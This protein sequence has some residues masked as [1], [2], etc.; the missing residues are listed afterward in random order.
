MPPRKP[1]FLALL[2]LAPAMAALAQTAPA[3]PQNATPG[4][5]TDQQPASD[6]GLFSPSRT[7][8]FGSLF[9]L[10]PLAADAGITFGLTETSEVLAN[11]T[12]G[13]HTGPA[14]E[15]LT[16][17]SLGI[18][19]QKAFGWTGGTFNAS[20]LQI[21]G[22]NLS[23]D[24]TLNLNTP[25]GIE[26]DRATRLWEL[27]YQQTF[28]GGHADLKI[29]QQ[30]IDQEFLTSA[31][32]STFI[33]TMMG[34]PIVPSYDLYAGGP[35]YPLSSLGVRLRVRP[36]DDLTVLAGIFDD[37]PPGGPFTDDSQL[38]G[39]EQSGTAFNLGT[40]ALIFGEVQLV[41]GQPSEGDQATGGYGLPGTYKLGFWYDTASFPAE[42]PT[43][44][45][46]Y[47]GNWSIYGVAD[48]TVW[49]PDPHAARALGVFARLMG[50]PGD[51][52]LIS[53][54]L[55]AGAVLKAPL[56]GR[57]NDSLGLGYGLAKAASTTV[58][59]APAAAGAGLVPDSPTRSSESFIELTYQAQ[60][61][62]WWQVQPDAQYIFMPGAG[63][64]DPNDA[65]RR[66]GNEAIFGVRTNITF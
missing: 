58:L 55:E 24:N 54:G 11:V 27:W 33:N 44:T 39:A 23:T 66:I 4:S 47:R 50:A 12:G 15:G 60:I 8:L 64:V 28:W 2:A 30:S 20:A 40:G 10:R 7:N 32:A 43:T 18:D 6:S 56:P 48:Q 26:A 16:L 14:Y 29:G 65:T 45:P 59:Q 38:R 63:V 5:S 25:S 51:R 49:Q 62:P 46:D 57:D 13:V 17:M 61:A 22:R 31:G 52:N 19:S 36:T 53:F 35:A 1:A 34:W 9:G 41:T 21:H 42:S 37:N 3:A